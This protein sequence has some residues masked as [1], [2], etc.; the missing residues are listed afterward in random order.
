M[1]PNVSDF[2]G[3]REGKNRDSANMDVA[4]ELRNPRTLGG[5]RYQA[6]VITENHNIPLEGEDTIRY[7]RHVHERLIE[8]NPNATT[9]IYQSW[10]SI[11]DKSNPAPWIDYERA[12]APVWQCMASRINASLAHEGRGD[13]TQ[14]LPAGVALATLVER[15]TQGYLEGI[16]GNNFAETLNRLFVDDVHLSALGSYYIGLVT[17]STLFRSSPQ[18]AWA[19]ASVTPAQAKSLQDVAWSA[20]ASHINNPTLPSLTTCQAYMAQQFCA[21]YLTYIGYPQHINGCVSSFSSQ[22]E[23]NPF[24]FNPSTDRPFWFS[25]P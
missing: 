24:W 23:R 7:A 17:Y 25:A 6:L 8:G 3:Y 13:R 16:S 9:Y 22:S 4:A 18:G 20:V 1:N 14:Y 2:P 15:A 10:Q 5:Q 11:K 19:P 21:R 12:A